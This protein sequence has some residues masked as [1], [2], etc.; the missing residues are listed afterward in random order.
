M[1]GVNGGVRPVAVLSVVLRTAF[2]YLFILFLMR[3]MGKREIGHLSP[4]DFVVAIMIAELAAMPLEAPGIPLW[5]GL[6]PVSVLVVLE[7]VFAF[8]ALRWEALRRILSGVPQLVIKD[9]RFDIREMRAARYNLD[10]ILEQLRQEGFADLRRVAYAVLENSG[11]LSVIPAE[12]E[13]RPVRYPYVLISDGMMYRDNLVR[14]GVS[15]TQLKEVL[16]SKGL[17]P[18]N[19]FLA[20]VN[21][22]G[23]LWIQEK[24][25]I[26]RN[27]IP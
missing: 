19:T 1:L 2:T 3:L 25:G 26:S 6:L 18:E 21:T 13:G 9:G 8:A 7:I 14:A 24:E 23:T 16:A 10:E 15:E 17:R 22:D 12:S 5:H 27:S 20:M 4:F 11:Q